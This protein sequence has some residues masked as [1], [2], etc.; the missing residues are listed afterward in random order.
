VSSIGVP[1]KMM[2]S[3]SKREKMSNAR[4]PRLVDSTTMGTKP[5]FKSKDMT[6][7]L[8]L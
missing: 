6:E 7:T 2:R 1:K 4:S 5:M 8:H 3:L